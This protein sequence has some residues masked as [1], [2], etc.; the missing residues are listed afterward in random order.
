M[1]KVR[2]GDTV[3]AARTVSLYTRHRS[4][5]RGDSVVSGASRAVNEASRSF[6]S[7]RAEMASTRI[8]SFLYAKWVLRHGKSHKIQK[9]LT[10]RRI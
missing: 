1:P 3:P 10:D 4:R 7:A 6:H 8:V 9:I 2:L 5:R